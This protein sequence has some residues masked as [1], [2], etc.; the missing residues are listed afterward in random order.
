[1]KKKIICSVI[2]V[3][4][5]IVMAVSTAFAATCTN[6]NCGQ[7]AVYTQ[8]TTTQHKWVGVYCDHWGWAA[9]RFDSSRTCIDCGY[10]LGS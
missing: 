2:A 3:A 1:M 9:H 7:L 8:K 5:L 6:P 4:L 10:A